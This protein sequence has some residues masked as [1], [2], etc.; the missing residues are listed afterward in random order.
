MSFDL[1][2]VF[3]N[4]LV[5]YIYYYSCLRES[6]SYCFIHAEYFIQAQSCFRYSFVHDHKTSHFMQSHFQH[7][8]CGSSLNCEHGVV[9]LPYRFTCLITAADNPRPPWLMNHAGA[10]GDSDTVFPLLPSFLIKQPPTP[11]RVCQGGW[12]RSATSAVPART[13]HSARPR[14][15]F[16]AMSPN[17]ATV[18]FCSTPHASLATAH[19]WNPVVEVRTL[20]ARTT[21]R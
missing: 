15:G 7:H 10:T 18:K 12:A 19:Q 9:P 4:L 5:S 6:R 11:D 14:P 13:F 17:T 16:G 21:Q 2:L 8:M 20:G 3:F 1:I